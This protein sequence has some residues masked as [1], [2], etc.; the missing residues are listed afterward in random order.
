MCTDVESSVASVLQGFSSLPISCSWSEMWIYGRAS[1]K[2]LIKGSRIYVVS[3][4][5]WSQYSCITVKK[6]ALEGLKG[7][8]QSL[9]TAGL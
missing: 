8:A 9:H 1:L 3:Q 4:D 7:H 5:S 2:R 6:C